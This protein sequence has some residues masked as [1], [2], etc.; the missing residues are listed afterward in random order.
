MLTKTEGE[1]YPVVRHVLLA[2]GAD[3]HNADRVAA[4]LVRANLSGVDSHGV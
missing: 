4:N 2:A 1:L 3:E